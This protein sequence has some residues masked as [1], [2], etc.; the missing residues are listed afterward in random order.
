MSG[1]RHRRKDNRVERGIVAAHNNADP[2]VLL[3]WRV[4]ASLLTRQ[5]GDGS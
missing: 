2:L 5:N 1:V 3:P 4:W